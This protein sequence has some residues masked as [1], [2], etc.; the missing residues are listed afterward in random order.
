MLLE[1]A[2]AHARALATMGQRAITQAKRSG[3]P[4][5]YMERELGDAIVR[6]LPDGTRQI[7]KLLAGQAIVVRDLPPRL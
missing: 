3:A 7:V 1:N 4:A 5:Y 6:E 2:A